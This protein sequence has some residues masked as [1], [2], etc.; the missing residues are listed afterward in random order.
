MARTEIA[1]AVVVIIVYIIVAANSMSSGTRGSSSSS[2][3]SLLLLPLAW[4]F[5]SLSPATSNQAE[6]ARPAPGGGESGDEIARRPKLC[7]R[8]GGVLR[9]LLRAPHS[10]GPLTRRIIIWFQSRQGGAAAAELNRISRQRLAP[11]AAPFKVSFA[12]SLVKVI[13]RLPFP[14]PAG[15]R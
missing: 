6:R 13:Q 11:L 1:C 3:R 15:A 7:A 12:G 9:R 14:A 2:S 4:Q 10:S 5:I 8:R